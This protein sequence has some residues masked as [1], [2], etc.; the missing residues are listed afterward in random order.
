MGRISETLLLY[1]RRRE[2]AAFG[3]AQK[4]DNIDIRMTKLK[5]EQRHFPGQY[6]TIRY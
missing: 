6:D 4:I 3:E 5:R 2:F 1:R